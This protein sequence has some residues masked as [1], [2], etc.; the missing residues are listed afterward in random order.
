MRSGRSTAFPDGCPRIINQ[1]CDYALVLAASQNANRITTELVAAAWNDVQSMPGATVAS[2]AVANVQPANEGDMMV[3]EFGHLEEE[4]EVIETTTESVEDIVDEPATI[5]FESIQIKLDDEN[6]QSYSKGDTLKSVVELEQYSSILEQAQSIIEANESVGLADIGLDES[7]QASGSI[8]NFDDPFEEEFSE[9][10]M[11]TNAFVP[12]VSEQNLN[13]LMISADQ[14]ELLEEIETTVVEP[15]IHMP[16]TELNSKVLEGGEI[17]MSDSALIGLEQVEED[18]K[19]LQRD[20]MFTEQQFSSKPVHHEY[21]F[22]DDAQPLEEFLQSHPVAG[23][24]P[25]SQKIADQA[26]VQFEPEVT[27]PAEEVIMDDRDMMIIERVEKDDAEVLGNV[28]KPFE[29]IRVST[30]RAARMEYK[31]L[32]HQ[33]RTANQ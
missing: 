1:I 13:S 4:T 22:C 5:E 24:L 23:E 21:E 12:V 27:E 28:E 20:L 14:L 19:R 10:E 15:Q 2:P 6:E 3:I 17:R 18:V 11:V 9:E 31:E 26:T 25:E 32:F 16:A 7:G 30:G 29:K 8:P 33:L